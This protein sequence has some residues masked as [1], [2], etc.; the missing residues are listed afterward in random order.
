M[1]D[2]PPHKGY[3]GEATVTLHGGPFNHLKV[4]DKGQT[5]IVCNLSTGKYVAQAIYERFHDRPKVAFFLH[6]E[7]IRLPRPHE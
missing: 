3:P 1:N 5:Q 7:Y 4:P 6:N 2:R